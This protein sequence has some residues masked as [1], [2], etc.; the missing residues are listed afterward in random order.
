MSQE[1][2]YSYNRNIN[3]GQG[4]YIEHLHGNYYQNNS[5]IDSGN[6]PSNLTKTASANFVGREEQLIELHQKLQQHKQVCISAIAGM[7]GIG[8][9][10]LALQYALNYGKD[11][12]GSICWFSLRGENLVTQIIEFARSYLNIFPPQE[13]ESDKAKLNYCWRNW[14]SEP[15][16][17]ILD[18]VANYGEFYRE[19]IEPYLPPATSKIKLLMTSRERPGTNISRI[20]LDVLSET[21]AIE[22]LA[23]LIGQ[24]KIEAEAELAEELCQW[25]GYLPLGIELVGRYIALDSTL[26]IKKTLRR[27]DRRKLDARALLDPEQADM[28]AQLGVATA[29]DLSWSVLSP[30]AQVL[31]CYLSLFGAAPFPW[32]WVEKAL[33]KSED[34]SE[35]EDE[36]EDLEELRNRQLTNRSLIKVVQ[37]SNNPFQYNFQLHSLIA[38]Y[39]LAKLEAQTY[40]TALKQKFCGVMNPIARSISFTPILEEIQT[41]AI[42]IPHLSKVATELTDYVDDENLIEPFLGLGKFYYGQGIYNQATQWLEQCFNVCRDRLGEQH[43]E[44]AASLNNLAA[45]YHSQGRYEAAEPLYLQTLELR[46]QLLPENHPEVVISFNNLAALYCDQGR[47]EAAEPLYLKALELNQQLLG[48]NH[49]DVAI[50]LNNLA[51]LY[52]YQGQYEAAEPLYLKALELN[53]QLLGENHPD[54]ATSLNNLAGLYRYQGQYEAAKPLYLQALELSQ[55]LLGENHPNVATSLNNLALLYHS[56]RQYKAAKPLYLKALRIVEAVLGKQHSRVAAII[57]NLAAL[58]ESQGQYEAAE[59]LY[60]QAL[61]IRRKLL[62]EEHPDVATS[63]NNLAEFYKSQGKYEA[64]EP[65]YRKAIAIAEAVLGENHPN[66]KTIKENFHLLFNE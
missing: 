62:R 64:A 45:L 30:D 10:E 24:S 19:N 11:Y 1:N 13:L 37:D 65:L 28:T 14:R 34:E 51:G 41:F 3:I 33:I 18:D 6:T 56:Q 4:N 53:Q 44:V 48:E 61:E 16:L 43:P 54:V 63:L 35:Q 58:Y 60:L 52:R 21:K 59:P 42:A 27:L 40:E 38:K 8:K 47:Y 7:G 5:G 36:R 23:K 22:L 55:Q 26:T 46:Q 57:N 29:F 25:L 66:T 2:N 12:S 50:S 17:I 31:G 9:T 49:P 39:F 32:L 15:S 20:D